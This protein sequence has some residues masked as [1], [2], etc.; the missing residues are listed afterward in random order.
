MKIAEY[1]NE[2]QILLN[3]LSETDRLADVDAFVKTLYEAYKTGNRIFFFGNGG[4]AA[5]ASH[6]CEDI[7]KSTI[8]DLETRSGRVKAISLTDNVP[9]ITAWANDSGYDQIFKQQLANLSEQGDVA[10][11][12]STS[13]N[14]PNVLQA[15]QF[16]NEKGLFT[17]GLTGF[18]GGK[19]GK[20]VKLWINVPSSDVGL[21]ENVHVIILHY[22]TRALTSLVHEDIS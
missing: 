4:S 18:L 20:I 3:R 2:M 7:A 12:I 6:F 14:S 13:G 21:I 22:V 19:L 15:I 10:V 5:S 9:Y 16:A 11:G 8:R 1:L 17:V